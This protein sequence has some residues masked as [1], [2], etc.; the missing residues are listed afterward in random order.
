MSKIQFEQINDDL[1]EIIIPEETPLEMVQ[2]LTKSLTARGLIEDS[3]NSTLSVR[4]FYRPE[5]KANQLADKLIKSLQGIAKN[6]ELPYWHP[7]AQMANQ[8]RVR[9]MEIAERRAKNGVKQP[10]N[11]SPAPEPHVIPDAAPKIPAPSAI[12]PV[13]SMNTTA[14]TVPK[15]YDN[16]PANAATAAGTGKRYAYIT[17]PVGKKEHVEGCQCDNCLEMEKSGYG[18]KG[19]GQYTLAD[20]IRRKAKNTGD[21]TGFGANV[22]TKQYTSAKF[23]GKDMQSSPAQ[24]RP[25]KPIKWTPEQIEAENKKRGLKKGWGEHL[26]FPSAEEEILKLAK[27]TVEDGETAAANQLANLMMGKQMLGKDVH[28]AVAAM[29]A[30]PPPQPTNE[31]LFGHLVVSE[32]MAKKAEQQWNGTLNNWLIEASKPI[33]Q[34]FASEEEEMAY[35]SKIKVADR[36]DGGSGY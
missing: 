21:Q 12:A 31:Q 34:R 24:K 1:I 29:M 13:K 7:K 20:N 18:P 32:E 35:W 10:S 27:A 2:Q 3:V 28:P 26:P 17:D 14:S 11:V 33:S 5:D 25:S 16:D 23:A 19:A 8:K 9:E 4:Y 6:D 30:P 22:N 15:M 36:D